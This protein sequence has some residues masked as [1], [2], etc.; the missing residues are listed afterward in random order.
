[1]SY[2]PLRVHSYYTFKEGTASPEALVRQ[3]GALGLPALALTDTMNLYGARPLA[4]VG[5]QHGIRTITGAEVV[6]AGPDPRRPILLAAEQAGYRS[7]CN[8]LTQA[9]LDREPNRAPAVS[10]EHLEASVR[11][12]ICLDGG[13]LGFV[14]RLLALGDEAGALKAARHYRDLFAAGAFFLELQTGADLS[15]N[16]ALV[17]LARRVD[18]PVAAT[19][20][21]YHAAPGEGIVGSSGA[22]R[23][24]GGAHLLNPEE[25]ARIFEEVPQA[26]RAT[27]E[28]AERCS[29]PL[30]PPRSAPLPIYQSRSGDPEMLRR[31][32]LAGLSRR[33]PAVTSPLAERLLSELQVIQAMGLAGYFL[34]LWDAAQWCR[35][36]GIP[37]GPGRGSAA[38]SLTCY[39]LGITQVDPVRHNLYFERFLNP[40]R[41]D[42]P[43]VD[44]DLCS[45]RR[46]EVL[47]YLARRYGRQHLAQAG[48]ICTLGARGAVRE[49]ARLLG[50]DSALSHQIAALLP[51]TSGPGG[52]ARAVTGLPE[53]KRIDLNRQPVQL[54][55]ETAARVEGL[56]THA[57]VHSAGVVVSPTPLTEFTP[58]DRGASGEV[59]TQCQPEDLEEVG[60]IKVDLLGLRNLTVLRDAVEMAASGG[61]PELDLDAL[62]EDDPAT[63]A[64]LQKGESIGCFQ[65]D[66]PGMRRMLQRVQ[67]RNLEDLSAVLSLYRPGPWEAGAVEAFIR[68]RAG[69]APPPR[70]HPRLEPILAETHGVPV[71]QEQVM[72]A[73]VEI[74]GFDLGEADR[75]R[76]ALARGGRL[77]EGCRRRFVE[78]AGK[79]GIRTAQAEQIFDALARFSG[80]SFNKAH[81]VGYAMIALQTAYLK[82]HR[83][84]AYF[85]A[86]L[87]SEG[88]YYGPEVY[89]REA[90]RMGIDLFEPHVNRSGPTYAPEGNAI[91]TGLR[92]V[93]GIGPAAA[94][95]IVAERLKMGCYRSRDELARRA[96]L[97]RPALN[98]LARAGA[99]EGLG[100]GIRQ[101]GLFDGPVSLPDLMEKE[102]AAAFP[103][104]PASPANAPPSLI[105]QGL[106][107]SAQLTTAPPGARVLASGTMV[108]ARR[109]P[110]REGRAALHL[111]LQDAAGM[112][113]VLVPAE[114]YE[115]DLL[116]IDP[117]GV[118]VWGKLLLNGA[119][120]RLVAIAIRAWESLSP[121][122]AS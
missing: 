106:R 33:Y 44:L 47:R 14:G 81:T 59:I 109:R 90:K 20:A 22:W 101:L 85:A 46:G 21:V 35:F 76:R 61:G 41:A 98:A 111:L 83:P 105:R 114:I 29:N 9:H 36:S 122:R 78:G 56:P 43:D 69:Q 34:V 2:V 16:R 79:R 38:G 8:L 71:Y 103:S 104:T 73:A 64:M 42:L 3:I 77:A 102:R 18:L 95:A 120:P 88:G 96:R 91:R 17:T 86:L 63:F 48:V 117:R 110:D 72:R 87:A 53:F 11:G 30:P 37:V 93:P 58:L 67:P 26:L 119:A 51:R 68:R 60:L 23:Q 27:L 99:L 19:H 74:A 75:L 45:R 10:P 28:I 70:S 1:M 54:L 39:C 113:E 12:L 5:T 108:S 115:R 50:A 40:D 89:I 80:Y 7:L 6:I 107:S 55:L 100:A 32:A 24:R 31:L 4:R 52:I 121:N 92:Q 15:L 65:L 118:A 49:A 97:S 84:A 112:V 82:V 94:A 62:P 13:P 25:M 57:S 66:S 116:E